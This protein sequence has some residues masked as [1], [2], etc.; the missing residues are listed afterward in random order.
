FP[1]SFYYCACFHLYLLSFPT[2]RSSDLYPFFPYIYF[3]FFFI[4]FF[5]CYRLFHIFLNISS[6]KLSF[7]SFFWNHSFSSAY[8]IFKLFHSLDR[9]LTR[10]NSSSVSLSY[11]VFCFIKKS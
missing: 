8:K 11:A 7:H 2:R 3:F 10:L 5:L 4:Y 6:S 9:K 1:L